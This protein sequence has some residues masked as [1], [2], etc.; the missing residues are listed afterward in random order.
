MSVRCTVGVDVGKTQ[1]YTAVAILHPTW[2][3]GPRPDGRPELHLVHL[4]RWR[5][6]EYPNLIEVLVGLSRRQLL[7]GAQ[8]SIDATGVGRAV[9]DILRTRISNLQGIT[10]TSGDSVTAP[11]PGEV[12]VPKH[13]LI[14][15]LV[16]A[17]QSERVQI[18]NGLVEGDAMRLELANYG[19]AYTATGRTRS[20]AKEGH[21]DLVLATALATW[22]ATHNESNGAAA[23]SSAIRNGL[24]R[25]PPARTTPEV[26]EP[27]PAIPESREAARQTAFRAQWRIGDR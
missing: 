16:Y 7:A 25:K 1:D 4:E 17:L 24:N 12:R 6:I 2:P 27:E 8:W 19:Y 23:W 13:D 14:S 11:E 5:R 22:A 9:T 26:V 20:G 15:G 3:A 18:Q 10:I 21:D